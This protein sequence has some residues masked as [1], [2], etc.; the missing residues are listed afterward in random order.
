MQDDARDTSTGWLHTATIELRDSVPNFRAL[1][2][3]QWTE[4]SRH[5]R[6]EGRYGAEGMTPG[7]VPLDA[8]K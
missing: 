5:G 8:D 2:D 1:V 6:S 3:H 7:N 4:I